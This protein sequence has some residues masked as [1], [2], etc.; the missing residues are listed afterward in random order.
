[1]KHIQPYLIRESVT[2]RDA[3]KIM[4][5]VHSKILFVVDEHARLLGALSDGDLRRWI[6]SEGDLNSE[7]VHVCNTAPFFL[8]PDFTLTTVK[9][10]MLSRKIQCIPVVDENRKIQDLLFWDT[11]F[12][13]RFQET[14]KRKIHTPV[15]IMA[16]GRGTRLEPFTKILPKPLIPIGDR[17][18]IE[19]I[20][21]KFL[22]YGISDFI[23]S[24]SHK[25]KIIKSF[26]EE[27]QPEYRI[28]FIQEEIPLGTVGGVRKLNGRFR[29][30][31]IL[32]NCD[33]IIE[34]DFHDLMKFHEHQKHDITIVGSLM[35]FKIPY[36][37]CEI[38]NGGSLKKVNE[39]PE[40]SYLVSTGMYVLEPDTLRFIPR[41][42]LFHMTDLI[43]KVRN[44]KGR[45]GVYPI[46]EDSWLDT[47][48]W[49]QYKQALK[50]MG[51]L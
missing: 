33:I 2:V 36:G 1:M 43:E 37:V 47:G 42:R 48:E 25:S 40:F 38:E 15:V 13:E 35:N 14:K 20:I 23:I 3:M 16:G 17:S 4:D 34:A 24:I 45:I 30:P 41:N 6:L 19:V 5:T 9:K 31:F 50:K 29:H 8:F 49:D 22:G 51:I 10:E 18:I 28:E 32:T 26:F 7:A 46:S 21:E 27:L 39:K 11:V 44:A 12:G